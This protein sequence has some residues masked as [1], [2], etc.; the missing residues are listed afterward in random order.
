MSQLPDPMPERQDTVFEVQ[1]A[2]YRYNNVTALSGLS[3]SVRTGQRIAILGANGS[4]KSTLLRLLDGLCFADSGSV[5]A[6]GEPLTEKAFRDRNFNFEFRRRVGLLFQDPDVQLFSPTVFDELAFGPLQLGWPKTLIRQRVAD[7]LELL[8]IADLKDRAPHRLSGGE[9]KRVALGSV[10]VFDPEVLLLDEPIAALDPRSQGKVIDFLV[11]WGGGAKTILTATHD[12][13]I[14]E[15]IAD[16]CY[17][18]QNGILAGE[19]TPKTVLND[20]ELLERT[21][22]VHAHR[23]THPSGEVHS[24]PHYHRRH[25]H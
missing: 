21:H 7:T 17:I 16:Y 24:H 4:G 6:Y 20:Q 15:E 13:D 12:L 18:F 11:A 5:R 22:L 25:E 19:G 10:L 14:V 1:D 3:V 9:K 23:H 2:V 8:E